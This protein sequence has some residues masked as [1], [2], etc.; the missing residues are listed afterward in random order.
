MKFEIIVSPEELTKLLAP[1]PAP[2]K[3]PS[4]PS[5]VVRALLV[6]AIQQPALSDPLAIERAAEYGMRMGL[7]QEP[8]TPPL[9]RIMNGAGR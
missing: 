1:T 9:A 5:A 2:T 7:G 4:I 3:E 6:H 8:L